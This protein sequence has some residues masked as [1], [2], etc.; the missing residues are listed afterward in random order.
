LLAGKVTL[1]KAS[2]CLS[3]SS[4]SAATALTFFCATL[5]WVFFRFPLHD[6]QHFFKRLLGIR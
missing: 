2:S 6:A 5:L 1:T 3:T 4:P